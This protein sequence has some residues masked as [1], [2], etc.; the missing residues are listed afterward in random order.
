MSMFNVGDEVRL[1]GTLWGA[2]T[3]ERGTVHTID[4]IDT[5]GAAYIRAK[6]NRWRISEP[7]VRW[8]FVSG[9]HYSAELVSQAETDTPA[10]AAA[11]IRDEVQTIKLPTTEHI[12]FDWSTQWGR[13]YECGLPAAFY[14][15]DAYGVEG[16]PPQDKNLR[17][18]VCAANAAADG[19]TVRRIDAA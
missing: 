9:E 1:T 8:D 13:C 12:E 4:E 10:M 3:P 15:P 5:E 11:R 19:E 16:E 17:C 2:A 18:A 6:G 14:L 7:G